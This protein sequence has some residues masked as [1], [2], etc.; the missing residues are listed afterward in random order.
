M[1]NE[2]RTITLNPELLQ[3]TGGTKKRRPPSNKTKIEF[4]N[5]S[6]KIG[7]RMKTTTK[8]R[9]LKH[10]RE[11]QQKEYDKLIE[12]TNAKYGV[13]IPSS[14]VLHNETINTQ[15]GNQYNEGVISTQEPSISTLTITN[16][17][18]TPNENTSFKDSVDFLN[19]ISVLPNN[20]TVKQRESFQQFANKLHGTT[21]TIPQPEITKNELQPI[22]EFPVHPESTTTYQ[23]HRGNQKTELPLPKYGCLKNG[24]LPT[25]RSFMCNNN[26]HNYTRNHRTYP[27]IHPTTQS[28]SAS[29][30]KPTN[31]ITIEPTIKPAE[32]FAT[33]TDSIWTEKDQKI[34][35]N[36]KMKEHV[37][38]KSAPTKQIMNTR[39]IRKT[40]RRKF[41]VGRS[42]KSNKIAVL[43]GCR[44]TRNKITTEK[45]LLKQV[46]IDD[47]K[48][49]LIKNGLIKI[50]TIAPDDVLRKMHESIV[51]IGGD[52]HNYNSE[53]SLYNY[54]YASASDSF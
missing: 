30:Y 18:T 25:Y 51:M 28:I 16:I 7:E 15:I 33:A 27:G 40:I 1:S 36:Q 47:I 52:V 14:N 46:K 9:L 20:T 11:K 48:R 2:K 6:T 32:S 41:D 49:Q 19:K 8:R 35:A 17:E 37:L 53:N 54:M 39:Q 50:G 22:T 44:K 38:A 31:N 42:K 12:E 34:I 43:I 21:V 29:T 3:I 13:G 23:I 24:N 10:L 26:N 45:Q 4:K 5:P